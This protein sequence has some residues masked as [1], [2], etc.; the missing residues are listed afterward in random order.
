MGGKNLDEYSP[1][2][3]TRS[4]YLPIHPSP[5]HPDNGILLFL[6]QDVQL[7]KKTYVNT[8]SQRSIPWAWLQRDYREQRTRKQCR[9]RP[10]SLAKMLDYIGLDAPVGHGKS[11]APKTPRYFFVDHPSGRDLLE[12]MRADNL[13]QYGS[14]N[15]PTVPQPRTLKPPKHSVRAPVA[16]PTLQSMARSR[17]GAAA[18][19]DRAQRREARAREARSILPIYSS[20]PRSDNVGYSDNSISILRKLFVL[21]FVIAGIFLTVAWWRCQLSECK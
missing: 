1:R 8:K 2:T 20:T 10:D 13:A 7:P 21:L 9:L 5:V 11:K 3:S 15:Q 16:A 18:E 12:S 19:A 17:E 6:D 14:F 4:F